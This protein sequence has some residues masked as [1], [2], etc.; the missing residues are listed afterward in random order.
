MSVLKRQWRFFDNQTRKEYKGT[1]EQISKQM[2]IDISIINDAI[3][4]GNKRYYIRTI[5]VVG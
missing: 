1:A 3:V 4:N 2:D 5:K